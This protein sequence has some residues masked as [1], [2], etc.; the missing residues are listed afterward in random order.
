V[1]QKVE[2]ITFISNGT[3]SQFKQ[4]FLFANLTFLKERY[5]VTVSWHPLAASHDKGVDGIGG[6]IR[7]AVWTSHKAGQHASVAQDRC[8]DIQV[9]YISVLKIEHQEVLD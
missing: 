7:Q 3:A 2:N 5:K 8:H 9:F 1:N 6:I 4:H